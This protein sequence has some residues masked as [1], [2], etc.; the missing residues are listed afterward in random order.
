M[1]STLRSALLLT[2]TLLAFSPVTA[3]LAQA[4][5]DA[6]PPVAIAI[7][8]GAGTIDPADMTPEREAQYRERLAAAAR[9]GHGVLTAGGT[10]LEAVRS[11]I[12]ILEDA[13]LFN[14]GKGAVFNAEGQ[15]ELDAS[16]M[17]GANRNAGAVASVRHIRNPID[18]AM[19]VMT[20]SPHVLLSGE[21]AEQFA[22]EQGFER[23]E[24]EYFDTEERW[25]QLQ[26][27]RQAETAGR[28]QAQSFF[29]TVGAVALDRHGNLAAGTSTGGM[30]NKR[31]GRVGDSPI[32]GAG[33]FADNASC[34]VSA[35]GHGEYFI[36]WV[37]AHEVCQRVTHGTSL[38]DAANQVI[39]GVLV[40]AGGSGGIIA[41][42]AAGNIA[43][44]FNTSG[45]Y[46]A[47]IS[48]NGELHTAI[49]RD[50]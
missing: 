50:R 39:N 29:S 23:V 36:R 5:A 4:D 6:Q 14:A 45:M 42:D 31:F 38:A 17:D 47:S 46:R 40:A 49:Y 28:L 34:A 7:H 11:A 48:T 1:L 24:P 21:G 13:P 18:L 3:G 41:M 8:G 22:L 30:T 33:T 32:I 25:L 10:A 20:H 26:K 44:P 9:A 19:R 2:A 35:T 27:A 43:M 37:V 15:H 16:I 12:N